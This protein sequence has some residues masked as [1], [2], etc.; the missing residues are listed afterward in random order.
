M[1]TPK[2]ASLLLSLLGLVIAMLAACLWP[3]DFIP[4]NRV[5]WLKKEHGLHFSA[6]G[7][8]VSREAFPTL[9]R[10]STDGSLTVEIAVRPSILFT[11]TIQ[12]ILTFSPEEGSPF[13]MIG[14]WKDSLIVRLGRP[15]EPGRNPYRELDVDGAFTTGKTTLVTVITGSRGTV[16]YLDGR[17]ASEW[18][19]AQPP[20]R[21]APLGRM[22]LGVT[23]SGGG[24]W[25]GDILA[26]TVHQRSLSDEE[27]RRNHDTITPNSSSG[28]PQA[29][30]SI[31]A[32][33][34]FSE[35]YGENIHSSTGP[36]FDLMIPSVFQPLRRAILALPS[37]KSL[38]LLWN[39][40]DVAL[41][42][43]GFIPFGFLAALHLD[44]RA[45]LS[46]RSEAFAVVFAGFALS[47]AIE[48]IQAFLP[49]RSSSL[50]D[51]L[52]NTLGTAMGVLCFFL[53]SYAFIRQDG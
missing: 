51:L 39:L 7:M 1:Y 33:Y 4:R 21:I 26:L 23:P 41:N 40:A 36:H 24:R 2:P 32:Q 52:T 29:Q 47:L 42:I 25:H 45:R 27:V 50:T 53:F 15:D 16:V 38:I 18:P 35:G 12:H 44:A 11:R 3:F 43:L 6:M 19:D 17:P 48:L 31:V 10:L 30:D 49:A 28:Y 34:A 37:K 46:S 22:L 20:D 13:L 5:V 9:S 8:V 14:A